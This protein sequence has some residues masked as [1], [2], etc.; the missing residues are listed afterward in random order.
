MLNLRFFKADPSTF[1]IKSVNGTV[2]HQGK[3]LSFWYNTATTS[4]A[5]LPLNAQE[6]PFIF[7]FQTADFQS[8]R[9]QG[10]LSFQ[11]SSPEKTAGV[12][13]F[14]LNKD[15]KT[16]A[17]EDPMKLSD[18]VVRAAQTIIQ[19]E[20]QATPLR[21]ALLLS[22]SLV[23]LV[24][25]RL[26][27]LTALEAQGLVVLDFSVTA[28]TPTPETARALEAEARESLMKEADDAI[29]ARRKSSVE[30]ERTI[31]EAE[32]ETDLS[33][34]QKE[35]EIEEAR[36]EN[37]R[38]LLREQAEMAQERLAAE[39]GEEEQRRTL[40]SL[41]AQNQRVQSEA[42]AYS[43]E[44]KMKAYR[45]LPVENLKALALSRMAPE[46]LMAMA[47]ESLAQNA[48]KIGELNI[49]P[50]MFSQMM[51]KGSKA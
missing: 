9:V 19:A 50:D 32:L 13:N 38:T 49:S 33:I 12:L 27:Q 7:N 20:I 48:G 22:Q 18:R 35:Q 37:E 34:Q 29:Y 11:I 4:V 46:Q 8:L 21:R 26:S 6:T 23:A 36:L 25:S 42:D 24:Q 16:Y 43:I 41:S 44:T 3:G 45:E 10:Q 40:V 31:K 30:Q 14:T 1:V 51:K 39:I 47:F 17:S 5:A 15:G 28:I 2:R